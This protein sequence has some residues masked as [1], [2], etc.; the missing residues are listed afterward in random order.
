LA[1]GKEKEKEGD[2]EKTKRMRRDDAPP[3]A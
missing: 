1:D 2:E 3:W